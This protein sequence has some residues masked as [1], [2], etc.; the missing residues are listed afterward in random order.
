[1]SLKVQVPLGGQCSDDELAFLREMGI[2]WV[3]WNVGREDCGYES[4][5]RQQERLQR[6]GMKIGTVSCQPLQKN[7]AIDLGWPERD[8][9]IDAFIEH[10]R[11]AGKAGIPTVSVAWQPNGILRT[12]WAPSAHTRG[13]VA[14]YADMAEILARPN[15]NGREYTHEEIWDNFSYFLQRTIPV[16]EGS[17]VQMALHPNDPPTACMAGVPSL[18]YNT[19]CYRRAFELAGGSPALGMKLC[20]GC[21]LE[22]GDAFGDLMADIAEFCGQ[23]K[24]LAVHFRNVSAP[25]PFFEETLAEDGYAEMYSIM[26]Q[27]ISCGYDG[28][29]S[30]D[31]AFRG[32]PSMGG[33]TGSFAYPTGFLK[34]LAYAAEQEVNRERSVVL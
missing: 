25:M 26:K 31:H 16:C 30:V 14:A 19:E 32:Y 2:E 5:A 18:I 17:D 13:G 33:I 27:F 6:F 10:I 12:G 24:V 28:F 3:E 20:V 23:G 1:M 22:A 9:E 29:I 4:L 21:W 11:A 7:P 15:A 34:G 8:G